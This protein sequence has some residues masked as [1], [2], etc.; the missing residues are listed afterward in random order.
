MGF[1]GRGFEPCLEFSSTEYAI[2]LNCKTWRNQAKKSKM[3]EQKSNKVTF[4]TSRLCSWSKNTFKKNRVLPDK[5]LWV[6]RMRPR[7]KIDPHQLF[8]HL[9]VA[10]YIEADMITSQLI[11]LHQRGNKSGP[12]TMLRPLEA[13]MEFGDNKNRS[14]ESRFDF[15]LQH[16][17]AAHCC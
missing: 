11:I 7:D 5:T 3:V 17:A 1:W 6:W 13:L 15:A 16:S 9:F 12:S 14:S 4:R 8:Q 10:R 2:V